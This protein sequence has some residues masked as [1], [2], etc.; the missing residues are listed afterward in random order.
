MVL[1]TVFSFRNIIWRNF[2][3]LGRLGAFQVPFFERFILFPVVCLGQSRFV[4]EESNRVCVIWRPSVGRDGL[5]VTRW[6]FAER[7]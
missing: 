4:G 5:F 3:I 7:R 1:F 2:L 6:H